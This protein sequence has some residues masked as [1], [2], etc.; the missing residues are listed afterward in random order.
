MLEFPS[1]IKRPVLQGAGTACHVGFSTA[2]YSQ[3]FTD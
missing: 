1:V 2:Q 3:I